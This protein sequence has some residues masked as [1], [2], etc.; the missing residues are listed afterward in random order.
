MSMLLMEW[1]V[2]ELCSPLF[3]PLRKVISRV[4]SMTGRAPTQH[5]LSGVVGTQRSERSF[6]RERL[7]LRL[8]SHFDPPRFIS[9]LYAFVEIRRGVRP[10]LP[11]PRVARG[12]ERQSSAGNRQVI[13]FRR[14]I[15]F[16]R[17]F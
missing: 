13:E 17:W 11:R 5:R 2:S 7:P 16:V 3:F 15:R 8:F 1:S 12:F 9:I 14:K 4:I 10:A 6:W